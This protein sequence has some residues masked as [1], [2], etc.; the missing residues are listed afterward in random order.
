[1]PAQSEKTTSYYC[2]V[3][4]NPAK[5]F[6]GNRFDMHTHKRQVQICIRELNKCHHWHQTDEKINI[7]FELNK[8]SMVHAHFQLEMTDTEI[9]NFQVQAS[10]RLG[11]KK[12]A[13]EICAHTCPSRMWKPKHNPDTGEDYQTWLEYCEKSFIDIKSLECQ[14]VRCALRR[15]DKNIL[16]KAETGEIDV[17][18]EWYTVY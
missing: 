7:F 6:N 18:E 12:L 13:P 4:P 5:C 8:R 1:M 15:A 11:N 14:C 16:A 10:L 3:S 17:P 2:T 9:H